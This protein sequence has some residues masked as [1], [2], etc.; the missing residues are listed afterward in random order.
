MEN[1]ALTDHNKNN[2]QLSGVSRRPSE[3]AIHTT[4]KRLDPNRIMDLLSGRGTVYVVEDYLDELDCK[5]IAANAEPLMNQLR[6]D[7]VPARKLGA[8]QFGKSTEAYLEEVQRTEQSVQALFKGTGVLESLLS[9]I[10]SCLDPGMH[11]RRAVHEGQA[12][13]LFRAVKWRGNGKYSLAMHDDKS[14]LTQP[15]QRGFEIQEVRVPVALNLYPVAQPGCGRLRVWNLQVDEAEKCRLGIE[16]TGYPYPP[17]A[18]DGVAYVDVEIKPGSAVFLDGR[19]IHAVT[20]GNGDRLLLNTFL[21]LL[22]DGKTIAI[23]T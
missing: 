20:A 4:E 16:H 21:G 3:F 14:Q 19:Y 1:P 22:E 18:L 6:N 13:G 9:A 17:E 12:A 7:Q 8:D 5:T 23:W 11:L 15:E 10:K 2:Q